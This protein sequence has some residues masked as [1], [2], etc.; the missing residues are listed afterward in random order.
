VIIYSAGQE[1]CG[2]SLRLTLHL[3]QW[4]PVFTPTS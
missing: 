4:S 1:L 3:S 2:G